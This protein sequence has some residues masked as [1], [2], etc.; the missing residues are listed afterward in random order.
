MLWDIGHCG[1][2]CSS[3][4]TLEFLFVLQQKIYLDVLSDAGEPN[5]AILFP[6]QSSHVKHSADTRPPNYNRVDF[7]PQ[8]NTK[9]NTII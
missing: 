9:S 8:V 2:R 6:F 3:E 5:A 1:Y 7:W 4:G